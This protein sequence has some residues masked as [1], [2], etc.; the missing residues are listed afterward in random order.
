MLRRSFCALAYTREKEDRFGAVDLAISTEP[1][2]DEIK[3]GKK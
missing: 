3:Y 2:I 1:N